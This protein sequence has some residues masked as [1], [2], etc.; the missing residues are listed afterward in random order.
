VVRMI[1]IGIGNAI[2]S[3]FRVSICP[4][5]LWR[6]GGGGRVGVFNPA[7]LAHMSFDLYAT[8]MLAT[9]LSGPL[10]RVFWPMTL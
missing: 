4:R 5:F 2:Q 10:P 6:S 9:A 8:V 7:A 3:L 1:W